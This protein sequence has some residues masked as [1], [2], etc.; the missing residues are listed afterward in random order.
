LSYEPWTGALP[1]R[2]RY[3]RYVAQWNEPGPFRIWLEH[4]PPG[5]TVDLALTNYDAPESFSRAR[6][7]YPATNRAYDLALEAYLRLAG[8]V[9]RRPIGIV[10]P[11]N[12]PNNQGGY[13]T[14][15][16]AFRPAHFANVAQRLC[17]A[18]DCA[19]VAGDIEDIYGEAGPYLH[20]YNAGLDFTPEAWGVHPYRA[21]D[22]Y[23]LGP[24]GM[25]EFE[26]QCGGCRPWFT[27]IGVF[28]CEKAGERT[29]YDGPVRQKELAE[30]LIDRVMTRYRP[31]HVFYYELKA[32]ETEIADS[33]E[34]ECARGHPAAT[35]SALYTVHGEPRP[36]ASVIFGQPTGEGR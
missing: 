8:E 17:A 29:V 28:Y 25:Q 30:V 7:N 18:W 6:Q 5:V 14:P 36:A 20:D 10:E 11:W 32:P 2:V 19:V 9:V 26:E 31:E 12:E 22:D 23:G 16:D 34:G 4:L 27:E 35:D 21:V 13:R 33:Q 1:E 15:S 24:S 3:A